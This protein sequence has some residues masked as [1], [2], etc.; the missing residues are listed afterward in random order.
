[1]ENGMVHCH[2]QRET[3]ENNKTRDL[4]PCFRGRTGDRSPERPPR[5]AAQR[6]G[7]RSRR[8]FRYLI[9]VQVTN[10]RWAKCFRLEWRTRRRA[11]AAAAAAVHWLSGR[12]AQLYGTPNRKQP[13]RERDDT[14]RD[15]SRPA[16]SPNPRPA[17][18]PSEGPPGRRHAGL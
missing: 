4:I 1:M 17:N 12:L 15:E 2:C 14:R 9:A 7:P 10:S 3:M 6:S 5:L 11:G 16:T 13:W 18:W 8:S